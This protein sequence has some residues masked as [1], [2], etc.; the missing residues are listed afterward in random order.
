MV[1]VLKNRGLGA[2]ARALTKGGPPGAKPRGAFE[3][4]YS[5]NLEGELYFHFARVTKG[6]PHFITKPLWLSA[7][8]VHQGL[9]YGGVWIKLF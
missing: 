6:K 2:G 1:D 8:H 3:K 9:V 4:S 7:F 5:A